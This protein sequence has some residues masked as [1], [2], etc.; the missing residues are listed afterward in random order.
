MKQK[1]PTCGYEVDLSEEFRCPRCFSSM[2]EFMK[3]HG[4][5]SECR[6]S[7]GCSTKKEPKKRN[8]NKS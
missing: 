3:C 1:C 5:C 6:V 2:I 4:N 7:T 8:N